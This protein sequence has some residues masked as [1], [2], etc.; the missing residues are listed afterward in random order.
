MA[1][2]VLDLRRPQQQLLLFEAMAIQLLVEYQLRLHSLLI[3]ALFL[4]RVLCDYG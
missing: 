4:H 3:F 1:L 2:F